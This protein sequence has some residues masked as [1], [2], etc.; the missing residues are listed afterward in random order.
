ML[1][2]S[3]KGRGFPSLGLICQLPTTGPAASPVSFSI[4]A[5][6]PQI[7]ISVRFVVEAYAVTLYGFRMPAFGDTGW[8][9]L[10]ACGFHAMR[11]W[12]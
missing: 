3:Q 11:P 6:L 12:S 10:R 8:Q 4:S 7:E 2:N 5:G 1:L 9:F